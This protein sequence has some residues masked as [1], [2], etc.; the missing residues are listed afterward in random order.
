MSKEVSVSAGT[1]DSFVSKTTR[2]P[3]LEA[4]SKNALT[5]PLPPLG[6]IEICSFRLW[7][8][9][10]FVQAHALANARMA[11]LRPNTRAF[12]F[13]STSPNA[14]PGCDRNTDQHAPLNTS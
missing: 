13:T 11:T 9:P 4:A 2:E 6:P 7:L 5:A 14:D 10:A 3:S 8:A 1:S 12:R